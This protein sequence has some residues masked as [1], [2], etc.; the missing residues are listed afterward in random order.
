MFTFIPITYPFKHDKPK[1]ICITYCTV[2]VMDYCVFNWACV[3]TVAGGE[4]S[5]T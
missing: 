4:T 3:I 2:Y 1:D 5:Q